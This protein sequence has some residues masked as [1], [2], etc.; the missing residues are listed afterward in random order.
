MSLLFVHDHKFRIKEGK[1]YTTGS[2]NDTV[3]KRYTEVFEKMTVVA[4]IIELSDNENL[5]LITENNVEILG[6]EKF[7]DS[8]K[9]L[10]EQVQ[11]CNF[12][13]IRL[14]S[15]MGSKAMKLAKKYNK[16]VMIESVACCWDSLNNH[17][18]VGK[19]IAP[20]RF[21]K[22]RNEIKNTPL[23]LY[24]T[25]EFLQKRYPTKGLSISCSDVVLKN[26]DEEVLEKRLEKIENMEEILHIG[27]LSNLILYKGQQYVIEALGEIKKRNLMKFKY[28]LVGNGN[29]NFL[30]RL[31][32][33]NGLVDEVIFVGGLPHNQIF[34]WLDENIDLYIQP[35]K[36]EGLPRSLIEA[37]S[38]ALPAIGAR[39]GGIPE[40]L[41]E[42][43]IFNHSKNR[44]KEIINLLTSM[45]KLVLSEQ[46]KINFEMAKN[47]ESEVLDKKRREFLISFKQGNFTLIKKIKKL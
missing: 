26:T 25:H 9:I 43:F 31:V 24:V 13:V 2:I 35:S 16:K 32:E 12:M 20:Y 15:F 11:R 3:L 17:S 7:S 36:Q 47:Y 1:F 42:N 8:Y 23:A 38:R 30:R 14:P 29:Q 33:K 40:L 44:K 41:D 34:K 19:V 6:G 22:T 18:L 4:R 46:A 37:M 21:I 10:E 39:T 5:Q 45:D 27:T 28:Y